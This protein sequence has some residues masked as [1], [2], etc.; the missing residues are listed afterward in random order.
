MQ[1]VGGGTKM[2]CFGK[3]ILAIV[4]LKYKMKKNKQ[5]IQQEE[6]L[7]YILANNF[8]VAKIDNLYD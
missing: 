3:L 6:S 7:H 2:L 5:T 4:C 1:V 8:G